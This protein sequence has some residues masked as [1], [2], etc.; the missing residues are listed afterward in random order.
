M[1][2]AGKVPSCTR[3]IE[4][5]VLTREEDFKELSG[6]IARVQTEQNK[7]VEAMSERLKRLE[8][9]VAEA[10]LARGS[11]HVRFE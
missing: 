3:E 10:R 7:K 9:A 5:L 2:A 4:L 6:M 11:G 1:Q 8:A